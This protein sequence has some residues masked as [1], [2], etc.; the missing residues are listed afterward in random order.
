MAPAVNKK[1]L[2]LD[3]GMEIGLLYGLSAGAA[4]K[5]LIPQEVDLEPM[6]GSSASYNLHPVVTTGLSWSDRYATLAIDVDMNATQR[7]E[8]VQSLSGVSDDFDDTQMLRLG[9]ELTLPSAMQLRAGYI[10]DLQGNKKNHLQPV[11][12]CHRLMS[13]ILILVPVMV[14][15]INLVL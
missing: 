4:V 7:F 2:N 14:A 10:K 13:S 9:G 8:N 12:V 3:L 6:Q 1:G 11:S 5:N 15:R